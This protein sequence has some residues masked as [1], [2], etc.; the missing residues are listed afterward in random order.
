MFP[1]ER[2]TP[3]VLEYTLEIRAGGV[4]FQAADPGLKTIMVHDG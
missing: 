2:L 4:A 1:G 3:E